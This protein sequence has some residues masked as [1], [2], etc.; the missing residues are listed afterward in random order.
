MYGMEAVIEQP[1]EEVVQEAP[2]ENEV[3]LGLGTE[4]V[5]QEQTEEQN[6]SPIKRVNDVLS[7]IKAEHPNESKELRAAYNS[8]QQISKIVKTPEEAQ[9]LKDSLQSLGGAEGITALQNKA[10]SVDLIDEG[11]AT[12]NRELVDDIFADANLSKGYGEKI[13]PYSLEKLQESNPKVYESVIRP[14]AVAAM[15]S[16]GLGDVLQNIYAAVSG[17]K[18]DEA[19][20]LLNRAYA[21]LQDQKSQAEKSKPTAPDPDRVKF[22]NEKKESA[23][24][25]VQKFKDDCDRDA[26]SYRDAQLDKLLAP[27]LKLRKLGDDTIQDLKSGIRGQLRSDLLAI[28]GYSSTL[29]GQFNAKDRNQDKTVSYMKQKID[30]KLQNA[31]DQV[32]KRRG[33]GA[34]PK[35][36]K[37][38]PNGTGNSTANPR[39]VL[40]SKK[41]SINDVD[42]STN[43]WM[44]AWM[45]GK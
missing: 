34:A 30:E 23:T 28:Q 15:E 21:W 32:W 33:Y 6:V 41:P 27:Y 17:N 13:I 25:Q 16:A 42:K 37:P 26:R 10:A 12:G 18:P 24:Q 1:V 11:I 5:E 19:K 4:E 22:E 38:N 45:A 35:A 31:I 43:N 8:W 3:E 29:N 36:G 39:V 44:E 14:H 7:K 9:Q 2:V 20:N 40:L